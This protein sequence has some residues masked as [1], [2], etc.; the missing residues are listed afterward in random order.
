M[1]VSTLSSLSKPFTEVLLHWA[2]HSYQY[3]LQH[4][5]AAWTP[6]TGSQVQAWCSETPL[7][8]IMKSTQEEEEIWNCLLRMEQGWDTIKGTENTDKVQVSTLSGRSQPP[9][10][11]V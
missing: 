3:C 9:V 6:I 2:P 10:K 7:S 8:L 11:L 4:G 1:T 5:S